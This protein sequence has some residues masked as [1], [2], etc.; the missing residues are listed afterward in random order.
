M[1]YLFVSHN[2]H[3]YVIRHDGW[4]MPVCHEGWYHTLL[5]NR[6]D[7]HDDSSSSDPDEDPFVTLLQN[8]GAVF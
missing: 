1:S 3:T 7:S 4:R 5:A 6:I 8:Q 2:G